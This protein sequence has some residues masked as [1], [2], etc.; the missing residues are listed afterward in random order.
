MFLPYE[1][2]DGL[3]YC[4]VSPYLSV[5]S[6]R[7]RAFYDVIADIPIGRVATY[8][9]IATL[10]GLSG[11]ARQVGYALAVTPE[12]IELPWHRVINAQGR[13]SPRRQTTLHFYQQE[14]LEQEGIVFD[15]GRV[16][17]KRY[18]WDPDLPE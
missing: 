14:L 5:I 9:Q 6:S 11:L 2:C 13:V 16:D 1:H 8:G 17:L 18:R 3:S 12:G 7:W 4:A 15:N 10:A